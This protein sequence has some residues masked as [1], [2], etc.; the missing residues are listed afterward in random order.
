[1]YRSIIIVALFA[2]FIMAKCVDVNLSPVEKAT[3]NITEAAANLEKGM[4]EL[5]KIDPIGLKKLIE[6]NDTL[7]KALTIVDQRLKAFGNSQGL[8][9]TEG[10]LVQIRIKK[11]TGSFLIDGYIDSPKNWI[12]KNH[13]IANE[14]ITLPVDYEYV[15]NNMH[16]IRELKIKNEEFRK[17]NPS[18]DPNV[19]TFDGRLNNY[20]MGYL[21]TNIH[22]SIYWVFKKEVDKKFGDYLRGGGMLP[23]SDEHTI[24]LNSSFLRAGDHNIQLSINPTAGNSQGRWFIEGEIVSLTENKTVAEKIKTFTISDT[25]YPSHI[26]KP[27]LDINAF[28]SVAL[29]Q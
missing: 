6:E 10:R 16:T 28:L 12:W 4:S 8:T 25:Q 22:N 27:I 26:G 11:H 23:V 13:P 19:L 21:A 7:K 3:K 2:L 20:S 17:I 15:F 24:D 9:I 5:G 1:M 18:I 14:D 29:N